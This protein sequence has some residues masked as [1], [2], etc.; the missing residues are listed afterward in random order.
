MRGGRII[1]IGTRSLLV[2]LVAAFASLAALASPAVAQARYYGVGHGRKIWME[3]AH[4][5]PEVL[6]PLAAFIASLPHGPEISKLDVDVVGPVELEGFCGRDAD[7]CYEHGLAESW[8]VVPGEQQED[9][10][11][12]VEEILAHEYG[13][14]IAA[15]RP[16]GAFGTPR[17]DIF[18]GVCGLSQEGLLAPGNEGARWSENPEELFAESYASLTFPEIASSWEERFSLLTPT[19]EGDEQ[20]RLDLEHPWPARYAERRLRQSC[21]SGRDFYEHRGSGSGGPT[22]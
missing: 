15:S 3:S 11:S 6:S 22:A 17:W 18:E 8:I 1:E 9:D 4:Y 13:H 12:T 20:I 10:A 7:G 2:G 5:G 14:H 21:G 19:P 16:G